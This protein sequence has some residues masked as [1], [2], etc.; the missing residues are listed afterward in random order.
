VT[1]SSLS[2][3]VSDLARNVGQVT[4]LIK[5]SHA[6]EL[7]SDERAAVHA[8]VDELGAF[9]GIATTMAASE[10]APTGIADPP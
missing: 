2:Q 10:T 3:L 4:T 1:V 6:A 5:K 7:T 8:M 9:V